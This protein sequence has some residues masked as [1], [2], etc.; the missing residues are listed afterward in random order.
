FVFRHA[1]LFRG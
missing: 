1:L